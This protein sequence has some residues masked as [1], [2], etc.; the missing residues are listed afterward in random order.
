MK[1]R[2]VSFLLTAL[3]LMSIMPLTAHAEQGYLSSGLRYTLTADGVLTIDGDGTE[4]AFFPYSR[5]GEVK[6][7]VISNV[8]KLG[9][10]AFYDFTALTEVVLVDNLS[11][12]GRQ[13]F[14]GCTALEKVVFNSKSLTEIGEEAFSGCTA[15]KSISI[16]YTVT[17]LGDRAFY[18]TG[19]TRAEV[20]CAAGMGKGVFEDCHSLVRA[21]LPAG[22]TVI[23]ERTFYY[24][25]AL[26]SV[27]VPSTVTK[28]ERY[29]FAD[30]WSLTSIELPEGLTDI[31]SYAFQSTRSLE[32]IAIPSTVTR[33]NSWT[34]ERSGLK[35]VTFENT[36]QSIAPYAFT[37]CGSITDVYF[38]G[39]DEEW[40]KV[41]IAV[42]NL[43]IKEA[44]IHTKHDTD[45]GVYEITAETVSYGTFELPE[46]TAAVGSSY[47]FTCVPDPGCVLVSVKAVDEK[48]NELSLDPGSGLSF[49]FTMPNC[50]VN[51]TGEFKDK[52]ERFVDVPSDAYY[53]KAVEWAVKNNIT[54]GAGANTFNPDGVC[55]RSQA[56][57]FLWRLAG[58]PEPKSQQ[59]PFKDVPTSAYF[60]KAVI[61]AAENGI[62]YGAEPDTFDPYSGCTRAQIAAFIYRY[63]KK[64]AVSS[65]APFTDVDPGAYYAN[66]VNWGYE[67]GVIYGA[68]PDLFDPD[69]PCT[70]AQIVTFLYRIK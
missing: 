38:N 14:A 2:L 18:Q 49:S 16:P 67:N 12:I 53:Y 25:D 23:P 20:G 32:S 58:S 64:P 65:S 3:L 41:A 39:T 36:L 61:W 52:G 70:R 13:A 46:N 6:K 68:E 62:V 35:T 15:L 59:C 8:P 31:E 63:L 24:C 11:V 30:C 55:N 54:A 10:R 60:Y 40:S 42:N 22:M 17:S 26:A 44:E 4:E 45:P 43:P 21:T 56:V 33:I 1:K 37:F 19:L 34:F 5:A 7:L 69:S 28:I 47:T 27:N 66:A 51:I 29:A 57:A 9:E 48:G 50:K